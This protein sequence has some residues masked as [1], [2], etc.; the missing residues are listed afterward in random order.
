MAQMEKTPVK[1][2]VILPFSDRRPTT[3]ERTEVYWSEHYSH[4][5]KQ[6]IEEIVKEPPLLEYEFEIERSSSL[7][8]GGINY[9]IIW[10]LSRSL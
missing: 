2:Y 1:I 4:F 5:I 7:Q 8:G 9:E 3:K 10:D 6:Q